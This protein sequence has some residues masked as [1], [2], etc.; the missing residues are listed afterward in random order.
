MAT[1][2]CPTIGEIDGT[3]VTSF[4]PVVIF[5]SCPFDQEDSRVCSEGQFFVRTECLETAGEQVG[6]NTLIA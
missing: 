1:E 2:S 6:A 3:T 5:V 4:I